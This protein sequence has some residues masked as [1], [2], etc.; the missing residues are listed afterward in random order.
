MRS[1]ATAVVFASLLGACGDDSSSVGDGGIHDV[2]DDADAA[3]NCW[4]TVAHIPHG[5]VE[6]GGGDTA[7]EA[8]PDTIPIFYGVQSG[9]GVMVRTRM[10]GF[11]P[12][13]A[14]FPQPPQT[15]FTRFRASF[16][17]RTDELTDPIPCGYQ[18]QYLPN[19]VG[20]Y[21]IV[22]SLSIGFRTCW[23]TD[24]LV[25]AK[26]KVDVEMLDQA[27]NYATNS[28]VFT[29]GEPDVDHRN[30]TTYCGM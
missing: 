8:M 21:D 14:D 26:L 17:D 1:F 7:F 24:V 3:N 23:G 22:D 12:G 5:T 30:V 13:Q 11:D 29:A 2:G 4:P 27:G 20:S 15:A 25:G 18:R 6:L 10:T 16:V 19:S 9:F 28:L